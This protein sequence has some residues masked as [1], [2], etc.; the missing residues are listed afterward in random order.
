MPNVRHQDSVATSV[1]QSSVRRFTQYKFYVRWRPRRNQ[2]LFEFGEHFRLRI[3]A[4]DF[5]AGQNALSNWNRKVPCSHADIGDIHACRKL[6]MLQDFAGRQPV[7]PVRI[8]KLM[9]FRMFESSLVQ[10]ITPSTGAV[11]D[12][13]YDLYNQTLL[14]QVNHPPQFNPIRRDC[15]P[16]LGRLPPDKAEPYRACN[17]PPPRGYAARK[18]PLHPLPPVWYSP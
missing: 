7:Q 1:A 9:C 12:R 8:F 16:R 4:G 18:R 13:A 5:S 17:F 10:R 6:Q 3:D 2:F 11:A 14:N 15:L